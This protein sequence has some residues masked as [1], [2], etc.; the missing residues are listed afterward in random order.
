MK[1]KLST[2]LDVLIHDKSKEIAERFLNKNFNAETLDDAKKYFKNNGI[3]F[4]IASVIYSL[5]R[6][7]TEG[8]AFFYKEE[9]YKRM[10]TVDTKKGV[11]LS[12]W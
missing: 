7:V 12:L 2:L 8:F 1:E 6:K 10:L 9:Q 3:E 11:N 4:E 5:D